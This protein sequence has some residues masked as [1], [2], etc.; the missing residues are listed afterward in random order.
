MTFTLTTNPS[1]Q[2]GTFDAIIT[3]FHQLEG[4]VF[5]LNDSKS[6]YKFVLSTNVLLVLK[7]YCIFTDNALITF[8]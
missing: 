5:L 1:P 7:M 3:N 6:C 2:I 8:L 4:N